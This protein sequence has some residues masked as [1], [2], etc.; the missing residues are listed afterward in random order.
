VLC[1]IS[2]ATAF[3]ALR[4][5]RITQGLALICLGLVALNYSLRGIVLDGNRP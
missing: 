2:I 4:S 1:A 3:S 5:W